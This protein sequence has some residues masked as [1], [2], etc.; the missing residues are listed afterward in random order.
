MKELCIS[1]RCPNRGEHFT[2]EHQAKF[3]EKWNNSTRM[4]ETRW[5]YDAESLFNTADEFVLEIPCN[6]KTI[7]F[8]V[9]A[10]T[11]LRD[12]LNKFLGG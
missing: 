6:L 4:F 3:G 12:A 7:L 10:A 8:N 2:D 1:P 9:E 11:E 5:Y